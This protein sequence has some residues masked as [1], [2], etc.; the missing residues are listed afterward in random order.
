MIRTL[1]ASACAL[2][3]SASLAQG[4]EYFI[5]RDSAGTIVLSNIT[6]PPG[7]AVIKRE[8]LQDV[9]DEELRAARKREHAFWQRLKDEKVAESNREL[10]ESNNRL[11]QAIITAAAL[12]DSEPDLVQVAVANAFPFDRFRSRR[13]PQ[14]GHLNSGFRP[15]ARIR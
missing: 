9:T 10:A 6:P 1:L 5:Y 2:G 15:H 8:E 13:P 14:R 11:A 4:A 7:A 12:R 3:F